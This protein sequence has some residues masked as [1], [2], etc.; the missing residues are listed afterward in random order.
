MLRGLLGAAPVLLLP[1][2]AAAADPYK[3]KLVPFKLE[4]HLDRVFEVHRD[5]TCAAPEPATE[6]GQSGWH[7]AAA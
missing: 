5:E 7:S 1:A 2:A 3:V 6:R 4:E